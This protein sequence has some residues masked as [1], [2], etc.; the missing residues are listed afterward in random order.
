[1]SDEQRRW[2]WGVTPAVAIFI[3]LFAAPLGTFLAISF[4]R[5]QLFKLTPAF[6]L[7]NYA[8]VGREY[9]SNLAFTVVMAL[10]ISVVANVLAFGFAYALRFALGRWANPMLFLVMVSMFG[11]YLIKIYAWKT[12]LGTYGLINT[13]LLWLG[14]V[15]EPLG[16][17]IYHPGAVAVALIHYLFPFAI[18]PI[19]AAL[20][21][22]KDIT[23][24][25]ARDLGAS[26]WRV[27]RDVVLPQA[28]PGVAA[29]MT[30]SFLIAAGDFVTPSLVG[31]TKT[32]MVG[33]YIHGQFV[34][35]FNWPLGAALATSTL[36]TCGLVLTVLRWSIT[37]L[38]PRW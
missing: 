27:F 13:L 12:I 3:G 10:V 16:I 28:Q 15:R 11:G 22:I 37:R 35:S 17:F 25:A 19:Y 14:L 34:E 2:H 33:S 20:R 26:P 31:G 30:F 4:W 32:L 8:I 38:R 23:L 24:E 29:A 21:N 6:T 18:L 9:H 7:E 36:V 1:M 5:V